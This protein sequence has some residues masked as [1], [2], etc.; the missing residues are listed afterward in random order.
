MLKPFSRES[1]ILK[2]EKLQEKNQRKRR[3]I[4]R[5]SFEPLLPGWI[6]LAYWG[7][8]LLPF[9]SVVLEMLIGLEHKN[10]GTWELFWRNSGYSCFFTWLF[11]GGLTAAL[12]VI[13][14]V[15]AEK[16]G[17]CEKLYRFADEIPY[18][19]LCLYAKANNPEGEEDDDLA[20]YEREPEIPTKNRYRGMLV[21]TAVC[22]AAAGLYYGLS[23]LML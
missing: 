1:E 16:F 3:K 21:R 15:R 11:L 8:M 13:Q 5:A 20:L 22:G 23:L 10:D 6:R 19:E 7:M 2:K 9:C 14:L 4:I 17:Y 12:C 18:E